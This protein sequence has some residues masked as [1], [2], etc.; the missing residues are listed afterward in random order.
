MP[1]YM[2][3]GTY[4]GDGLKG[5]LKEGGTARRDVVS[6]LCANLGGE[7]EA[8]YYG[9]GDDDVHVIVDL[10]DNVTMAALSLVANATGAVRARTTVLLTPE[11]IDEATHKSIDYRPAAP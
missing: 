6:K 3:S 10:P 9:F 5:L 8:A 7:L 4:V 1:K 2:V 11:E